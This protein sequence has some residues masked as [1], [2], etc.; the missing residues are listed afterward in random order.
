MLLHLCTHSK[1]RNWTSCIKIWHLFLAFKCT[2]HFGISSNWR[3]NSKFAIF[4]KRNFKPQSKKRKIT[5]KTS[6][7]AR[8]RD[9]FVRFM[10]SPPRNQNS[11]IIGG[12]VGFNILEISNPNSAFLLF[13]QNTKSKKGEKIWKVKK[14]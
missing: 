8:L 1:R 5:T 9:F 3:L 2:S 7:I 10:S 12:K 6:L 11:T 14:V 4:Q 13:C